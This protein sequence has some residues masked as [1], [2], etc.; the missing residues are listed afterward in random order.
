M[1]IAAGGTSPFCR[2]KCGVCDVKKMMNRSH[3]QISL[4]AGQWGGS[5]SPTGVHEKSVCRSVELILLGI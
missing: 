1:V 5:P 2:V 4:R 3:L